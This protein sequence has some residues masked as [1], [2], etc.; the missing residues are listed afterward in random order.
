MKGVRRPSEVQ[1]H[2]TDREI[3]GLLLQV[4]SES[5]GFKH[6]DVFEGFRKECVQG[7]SI[8]DQEG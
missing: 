4:C 8:K 7:Y 3:E 2:E 1:G 6:L 5:K